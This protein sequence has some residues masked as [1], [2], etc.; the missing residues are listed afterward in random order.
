[1]Q[2]AP[3]SYTPGRGTQATTEGRDNKEYQESLNAAQEK[4]NRRWEPT[5]LQRQER[6]G[7]KYEAFLT[8]FPGITWENSKP[9]DVLVFLERE[10]KQAKTTWCP[11]SLA[12]MCSHLS[13]NFQRRGRCEE[14]SL[15]DTNQ[16]SC[17]PCPSLSV[18]SYK[19][20]FRKERAAAGY[21]SRAAVP[22]QWER[23]GSYSKLL[24][25]RQLENTKW[26]DRVLAARDEVFFNFMR[27][28]GKRGGDSCR[29]N[30]DDF[31]VDGKQ[32]DLRTAKFPVQGRVSI[33]MLD[34]THLDKRTDPIDLEG[35]ES[36]EL[37]DSLQRYRD[38][39]SEGCEIPRQVLLKCKPGKSELDLENRAN[40]KLLVKRM[41]TGLQ[42]AGMYDGETTHSV[43]RGKY[44]KL[45]DELEDADKVNTIMQIKNE[46]TGRLYGDKG[47]HL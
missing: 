8:Q 26:T 43:R 23:A 18:D 12:N 6:V 34:K 16:V 31:W 17:N 44:Q 32:T 2:T 20:Q 38:V 5:V 13:M 14:W 33:K 30:W 46:H 25:K 4:L 21:V 40:Q 37:M 29:L 24:K 22:M 3:A 45:M 47:R 10:Q 36:D 9:E 42:D 15:R 27:A 39:L 41:K 11:Q 1:M 35:T 7:A 28:T 19:R